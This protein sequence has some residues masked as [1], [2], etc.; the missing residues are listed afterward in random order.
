MNMGAMEAHLNKNMKAA[1]MRE[2]MQAK[3]EAN[4]GQSRPSEPSGNAGPT[5]SEEEY[6]EEYND[7]KFYFETEVKP[8]LE[9]LKKYIGTS[10]YC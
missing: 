10:V 9:N 1:K 4:K 3:A 5:I 8:D 2:R 7:D 6:M